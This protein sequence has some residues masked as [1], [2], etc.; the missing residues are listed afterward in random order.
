MRRT[1]LLSVVALGLIA[2][3]PAAQA[4]APVS[5]VDTL[6][7]CGKVKDQGG[8]SPVR[9]ANIHCERARTL[10]SDFIQHGVIRDGWATDNPAG[11]EWFMFRNKSTDEYQAWVHSGGPIGFRLIYFVKMKGCVS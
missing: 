3:L 2:A 5:R 11:C 8:R 6:H 7:R 9:A 10:A 1:T 4:S